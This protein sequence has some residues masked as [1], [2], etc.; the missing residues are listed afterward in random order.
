M[1]HRSP[2]SAR[3][4]A[5]ISFA[6]GALAIVSAHLVT[7]ATITFSPGF[8]NLLRPVDFTLAG[9]STYTGTGWYRHAAIKMDLG[10]CLLVAGSV[11][12][13]I[14]PRHQ[15]ARLVG[16]CGAVLGALIVA[17]AAIK[18]VGPAGT[19][20]AFLDACWTRGPAMWISLASAVAG[21]A[22]AL[23]TLLPMTIGTREG[24]GPHVELI[25]SPSS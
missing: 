15:L 1:P 2:A 3:L 14:A 9:L 7:W 25:D 8:L 10:G 18:S 20:T 11:L 23:M 16:G 21:A 17:F 6:S 24:N 19:R 4:G 13:L 12:V 5:L 22:G